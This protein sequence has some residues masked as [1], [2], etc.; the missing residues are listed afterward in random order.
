MVID[1]ERCND[2]QNIV[3]DDRPGDYFV[4][5]VDAG[6]LSLVAGPYASHQQALDHVDSVRSIAE[7]CDPRACFYFF[8]TARLEPGSGRIGVL[9]RHGKL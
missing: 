2:C 1:L 3:V 4:S 8:G 6:K 5:A 9:N 7:E